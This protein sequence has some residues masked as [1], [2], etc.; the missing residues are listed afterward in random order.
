[1]KDAGTTDLSDKEINDFLQAFC[2]ELIGEI[3]S[4]LTSLAQT[5]FETTSEVISDND[6]KVLFYISGYIIGALMKKYGKITKR[7]TRDTKMS[8][9]KNLVSR[10]TEKTFTEKYSAMYKYKDRC[11]LKKP[12]DD[13]F[14]MVREFENV[15]RK[16]VNHTQIHAKSFLKTELTDNIMDSFMVKHYS[17]ILFESEADEESEK[18]HYLEDCIDYFLTV[19]GFAVAKLVNKQTAQSAK[20]NKKTSASLRDALKTFNVSQKSV[21][22]NSGATRK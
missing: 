20:E 3:F 22:K 11:G 16:Q 14:F 1:M 4:S 7:S 19:R 12:C 21:N 5:T 2:L 17:A 18:E 6:T 13:F 15:V 9:A 8:V 10:T